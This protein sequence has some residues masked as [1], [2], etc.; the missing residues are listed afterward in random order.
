MKLDLTNL[1][2]GSGNLSANINATAVDGGK[3]SLHVNVSRNINL[4]TNPATQTVTDTYNFTD[5]PA[6]VI[7]QLNNLGLG[8]LVE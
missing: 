5:T 1:S 4:P 2:L 8:T 3:I 7:T 6:N